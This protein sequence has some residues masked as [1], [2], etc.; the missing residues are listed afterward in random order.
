VLDAGTTTA[1]EEDP[2]RYMVWQIY[3]HFKDK[4]ATGENVDNMLRIAGAVERVTWKCAM[5]RYFGAFED[6]P[7]RF[8]ARVNLRLESIERKYGLLGVDIESMKMNEGQLDVLGNQ[9]PIYIHAYG[10]LLT[11]SARPGHR[12]APQRIFVDEGFWGTDCVYKFFQFMIKHEALVTPDEVTGK[13]TKLYQR[14]ARLF[15]DDKVY[16]F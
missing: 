8:L 11:R 5:K 10:V 12:T 9:Q 14:G 13:E 6:D 3:T 2:R 16:R 15:K 7:L 4:F 1:F